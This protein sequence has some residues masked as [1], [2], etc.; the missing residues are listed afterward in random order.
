MVSFG[1]IVIVII[2]GYS[3]YRVQKAKMELQVV[4][5]DKLEVELR[6]RQYELLVMRDQLANLTQSKCRHEEYEEWQLGTNWILQKFKQYVKT[7]ISLLKQIF[8]L[9]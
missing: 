9:V 2:I 5:I 4:R 6:L 7:I 1:Q 8:Q 3:F